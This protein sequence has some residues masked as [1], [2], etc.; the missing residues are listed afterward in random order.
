MDASAVRQRR[1][2]TPEQANANPGEPNQGKSRETGHNN[3]VEA[4]EGTEDSRISKE[5]QHP[6]NRRE[7]LDGRSATRA[8]LRA[9]E[10]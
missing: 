9:K 10:R 7:K 5:F 8:Y 3:K 4:R 2:G 6:N 1:R